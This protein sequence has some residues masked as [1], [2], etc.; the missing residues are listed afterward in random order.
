MLRSQIDCK[1]FS[2]NNTPIFFEIKTRAVAPIRYD[3]WNYTRY[4]DYDVTSLNGKHSSYEREFYDLIRGAFLKYIFQLKIG[5]MDG[6]LVSYHNTQ[7]IFGFEYVKLEDMERRVFGNTKFSDI[8]FKASL[9]MMEETLDH[10]INDFPNEKELII[11]IFANEWKGTL[12]IFVETI[13]ES[14]YKDLDKY[15]FKEIID[16][17]KISGFIPKVYKYSVIATPILN[18]V[19]TTFSPILYENYDN[20]SVKYKIQYLGEP[21]FDEYMKFVHESAYITDSL[22]LEN[23]FSGSWS[24][25]YG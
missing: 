18:N 9:K 17:Y 14:D 10:I 8:I 21:P 3:V 15:N 7:K 4:L 13:K 1:G 11:G 6:A 12:D 22:N 5:G 24:L 20:Y 23:Q 2:A 19:S 16:Y 25:S